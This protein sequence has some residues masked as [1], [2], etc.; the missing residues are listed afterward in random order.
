MVVLS[1]GV[2]GALKVI[3]NIALGFVISIYYLA[4]KENFI[5]GIKRIMYAIMPVKFVNKVIDIGRHTD[6]ILGIF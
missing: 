6:D 4:D 3:F 5:A 2:F 1:D